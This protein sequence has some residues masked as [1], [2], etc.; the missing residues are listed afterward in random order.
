MPQ[1][2]G[3]ILASWKFAEFDKH[4]RSRLWYVVFCVLATGLFAYS[5]VTFNYLFALIIILGS[6]IIYIQAKTEPR[7]VLFH[8]T[9]KGIKIGA[10]EY[11][12]KD[13][14][15]FWILY[16]PPA[17]KKLYFSFKR[18]FGGQFM[19]PLKNQNPLKIRDILLNFV[20]ED[21]EKEEEPAGEAFGRWAK[22]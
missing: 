21:L 16:D 2:F 4:S 22:L 15:S 7:S 6:C 9:T 5:L 11:R 13:I 1:T 18:G 17:V 14:K 19:V 10:R 3:K 12:Y 20:I 8:V